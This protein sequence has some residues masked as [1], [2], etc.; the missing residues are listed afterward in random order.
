MIWGKAVGFPG[1]PDPPA[2]LPADV[3][4]FQEVA[5]LEPY[6]LAG[7]VDAISNPA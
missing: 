3:A 1:C 6:L 5:S 7:S 2:P 4:E